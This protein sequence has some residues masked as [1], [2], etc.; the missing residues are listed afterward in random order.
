VITGGNVGGSTTITGADPGCTP[1]ATCVVGGHEYAK[2][3]ICVFDCGPDGICH[4]FP[5]DFPIDVQSASS[6][7]GNFTIVLKT[8]LV[9]GQKI[10]I[11]DGCT[12]PLLSAPAIVGY[13]T[14]A[15]LMS[16]DLMVVLVVA[17]GLVGLLGL[18][19][20]RR[21]P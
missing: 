19:R 14:E 16:R 5:D 15:P 18:A 9:P 6:I 8:P 20:L 21:S 3:N 11:T 7:N 2:N 13:P 4:D 12:D 10:Y 1:N 17:L